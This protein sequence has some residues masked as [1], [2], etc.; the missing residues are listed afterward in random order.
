MR[1]QTILA[2]ALLAGAFSV[3]PG[4]NGYAQSPSPPKDTA[5]RSE[6]ELAFRQGLDA[7]FAQDY[8]Q[9][10]QLWLPPARAGNAKAQSSIGHLYYKGLGR[11]Q[12]DDKSYPWYG[13]AAAQGEPTA[14][15]RL[16]LLYLRGKAVARNPFDA[17]MWCTLAM[18]GGFPEAFYCRE[19]A[20]RELSPAEMSQA[21]Q[22]G[23]EMIAAPKS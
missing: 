11:P 14:Q 20:A 7:Y 19:D 5:K 9:A 2:V 4:K 15:Y 6:G 22:R 17:Y 10:Y 1:Y 3:A 12:S 23:R 18:E 21:E 16:G 8:W 13:M